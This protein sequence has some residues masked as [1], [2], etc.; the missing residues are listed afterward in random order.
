LKPEIAEVVGQ[1]GVDFR[2]LPSTES[3]FIVEVTTIG[4]ATVTQKS[5]VPN[6]IADGAF[7]FDLITTSE[8]SRLYR[9]QMGGFDAWHR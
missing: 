2:A 5:G 9:Y 1:G 4:S 6:G 8:L 3:E 7:A